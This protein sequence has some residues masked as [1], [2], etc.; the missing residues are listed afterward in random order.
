MGGF[1]NWQMH[2]FVTVHEWVGEWRVGYCS[3]MESLMGGWEGLK[4]G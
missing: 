1:I 4:G 3:E 2:R